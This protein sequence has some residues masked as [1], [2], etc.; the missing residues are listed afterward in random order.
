MVCDIVSKDVNVACVFTGG[1]QTE[2]GVQ[3]GRG[4]R[5][6]LHRHHTRRGRRYTHPQPHMYTLMSLYPSTTSYVHSVAI[7]IHN[8]IYTL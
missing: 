1:G 6:G 4:F 5:G 8:L 3:Y 7:P 2:T